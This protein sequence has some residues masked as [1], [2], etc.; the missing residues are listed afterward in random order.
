MHS[1]AE[2]RHRRAPPSLLGPGPGHSKQGRCLISD[3]RLSAR[4]ARTPQR[5]VLA[6]PA[7]ERLLQQA[8]EAQWQPAQS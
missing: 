4:N 2:G 7:L 5:L 3:W 6:Q 1:S 8:S